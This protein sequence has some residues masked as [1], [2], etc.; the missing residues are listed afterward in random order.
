MPEMS[1][2][3]EP[4]DLTLSAVESPTALPPPS[5]RAHVPA[6]PATPA[7]SN[8][9]PETP[10]AGSIPDPTLS[11]AADTPRWPLTIAG[12]VILTTGFGLAVA[13]PHFP[14]RAGPAEDALIILSITSMLAGAALVVASFVLNLL[15]Q[16]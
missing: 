15:R 14:L 13:T 5:L 11:A 8:G 16:L 9:S 12:Y 10:L 1:A 3:V 6:A 2:D 4:S 7:P